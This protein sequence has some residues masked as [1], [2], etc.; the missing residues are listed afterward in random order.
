[1]YDEKMMKR[2]RDGAEAGKAGGFGVFGV[3]AIF[4]LLCFTSGLVRAPLLPD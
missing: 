3:D 1:L 2:S 4:R